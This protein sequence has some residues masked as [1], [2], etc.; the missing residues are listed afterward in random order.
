MSRFFNIAGPC[1]AGEHYMLPP[2]RR[3]PGVREL[4]GQRQYFVIHAPRQ[5]GKTTCFQVLAGELAQEGRYAALYANCEPAQAAGGDVQRGVPAVLRAIELAAVALPEELRPAALDRF[6][7]IEAELRLLAFLGAWAARCP[8][9]VVLF[10]DEI[11]SLQDMTLI[12]VLRQLRSGY[13]DRP[14]RFPQSIALI[15]L[16]DVR[17]YK[18]R[19]RPDSDS[20]GTA[21]PFNIKVRS[22]TLRNFTAEEVAELYAQHTEETGQRFR[23]EALALAFELTRGQPWLANALADQV[24][25]EEVPDRAMPVEARHVEAA[26]EALAERRDAHLDSLVERLREPRVRRVIEPI[27][28]GELLLGERLDDDVA[29]VEDLGLVEQRPGEPVRIANPIY[30]EVIPRALA[31]ISQRGIQHERLWYVRSDGTL[32][33]EGL[34][35]AFVQFWREH[36]E[37]LLAVQPYHDVAPQLV[38]MAFLQRI[39]NGGGF[40]DRGYAVGSGRMD[41]CVRW[42]HPG[43]V[44]REALELKVWR[45]GRPDPLEAGLEQLGRYLDRLDLKEGA[46]VLF[47]RRSSAPPLG[48]RCSVSEQHHGGR[49]IRVLRP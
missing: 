48:Q 44:Q 32:D 49:R 14:R 41:L 29:Y 23:P 28:A 33:M 34:L 17:D 16:R 26:K 8:K 35:G 13:A 21:S 2:E 4:I 12:S 9:P 19:V 15:G 45:D 7:G 20:L 30:Q 36:A 39:V 10:L 22:L 37:A 24:V 43:G 5:S 27:L 6:A 3:I 1:V 38:L 11:D 42:P 18:V 46:L 47:D 31:Y 40:I 25:R